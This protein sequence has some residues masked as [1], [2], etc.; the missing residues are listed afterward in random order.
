MHIMVHEFILLL[1]I[2][3]VVHYREEVSIEIT[4]IFYSG[5]GLFILINQ[6]F[7]LAVLKMNWAIVQLGQSN[8]KFHATKPHLSTYDKCLRTNMLILYTNDLPLISI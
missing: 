2:Y 5:L 8:L 3:G 4:K 7:S 6:K 1:H